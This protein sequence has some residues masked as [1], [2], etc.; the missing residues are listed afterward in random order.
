MRK[1]MKKLAAVLCSAAFVFSMMPVVNGFA[2]EEKATTFTFSD[3]G[4]AVEEGDYADYKIDGT[5]I[6]ITGAGKYVVTGNCSDGSIS[7]KK[8][9]TDVELT[10][11]DLT[12]T[13]ES[14]APVSVGKYTKADIIIEGEVYLTDSLN[15]SENYLI[16]EKEMTEDEADDAGAENAVIK[17]KGASQVTISGSGT[18]NIE[19]KAKNGIKSGSALDGEGNEVNP[20]EYFDSD[21]ELADLTIKDITLNINAVYV[22]DPGDGDTYGD[23]INGECYVSLYS[24]KY[25]IAAGDDAVHSDYALIIG[26]KEDETDPV[27]TVLSCTEG[28]EGAMVDIAGG[29]INIYAEDDA[30][31]AANSDISFSQYHIVVTGGT[32]N[33]ID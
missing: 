20:A 26:N 7:V 10:L 14:T 8:E 25:T 30:I 28:L 16:N 13:S 1:T 22:Y 12:L 4:I 33:D 32:I 11:S 24:G 15:N 3:S 31:N 9:L 6:K 5:E 2:A 23:A 19:A 29:D 21:M 17:L 18:L 27:I